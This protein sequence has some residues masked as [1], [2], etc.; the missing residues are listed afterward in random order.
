MKVITIQKQFISVRD[1]KSK[2]IMACPALLTPLCAVHCVG[3]CGL[4][5]FSPAHGCIYSPLVGVWLC[6]QIRVRQ[7]WVGIYSMLTAPWKLHAVCIL[8]PCFRWGIHGFCSLPGTATSVGYLTNC[9]STPSLAPWQPAQVQHKEIQ[10][11]VLR[12]K[13]SLCL[14]IIPHW[15]TD[16]CLSV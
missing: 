7:E 4:R 15:E 1:N 9:K 11:K 13:C 12:Q 14:L 5:F 6:T 2:T 8:W 3:V 16:S 10:F